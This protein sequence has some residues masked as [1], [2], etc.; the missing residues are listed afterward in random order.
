MTIAIAAVGVPSFSVTASVTPV[1]PPTVA[2]NDFIMVIA[3]GR[4]LTT[5]GAIAASGYI[6]RGQVLRST[7]T[8]AVLKVLTRHATGG[9]ADPVITCDNGAQGWGAV[10]LRL[11]GVDQTN[12]RDAYATFDTSTSTLTQ[13]G[14]TVTTLSPNALLFSYAIT[15]DDNYLDFTGAAAPQTVHGLTVNTDTTSIFGG[16]FGSDITFAAAGTVTAVR[17][18]R[19]GSVSTL[20][21][22]TFYVYDS[23]G[24]QIATAATAGETTTSGWYTAVLG[25]P[26]AVTAGQTI[27]VAYERPFTGAPTRPVARLT[28]SG[29]IVSGDLTMSDSY[30]TIP[31]VA[32]RPTT[33]NAS[34]WYMVDVVFQ[35]TVTPTTNGFTRVS[36]PLTWQ[37][38][39]GA[40][41]AF[42]AAYKRIVTPGAATGPTW[43]QLTNGP[44]QWGLMD[45]SFRDVGAISGTP[46]SVWDG[47]AETVAAATVWNGTIEGDYAS[48]EIA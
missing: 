17:Y 18:Y 36:D 24:T 41:F 15:T 4:F 47:T 35:K 33:T 6:D 31:Y 9:D 40:D 44:D 29:N 34:F 26:L 16:V 28:R 37:T 2:A 30:E 14:P 8:N 20:T 5:D 10:V 32:G 1:I 48:W 27:R 38:L 19:P 42:A 39:T 7:S 3:A 13:T 45:M 25:T 11:T 46:F 22:T 12:P 23:G 43:E 21:S